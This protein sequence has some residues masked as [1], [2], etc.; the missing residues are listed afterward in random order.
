M[1]LEPIDLLGVSVAIFL[2]VF[3]LLCFALDFLNPAIGELLSLIP[4]FIGAIFFTVWSFCKGGRAIITKKRVLK[5]VGS[6]VGEILPTGFLPFW[7]IFIL[8]ELR[9]KKQ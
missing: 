6:L 7:T 2:D 3:G 4:D 5:F 9:S 8:S 1:N